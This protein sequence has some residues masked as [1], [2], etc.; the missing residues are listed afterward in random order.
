MFRIVRRA[1]AICLLAAALAA[2]AAAQRVTIGSGGAW[3]EAP[4]VG[5]EIELVRLRPEIADFQMPRVFANVAGI[6]FAITTGGRGS[7]DAALRSDRFRRALYREA[8]LSAVAANELQRLEPDAAEAGRQA[9]H[10]AIATAVATVTTVAETAEDLGGALRALDPAMQSP[11]LEALAQ[12][13][14][15]LGWLDFALGLALDLASEADRVALLAEAAADAELM[16]TLGALRRILA[17]QTRPDPAMLAGI[18][19]A[20]RDVRQL[21][22]SRLRQFATTGGRA[23]VRQAVPLGV[24]VAGFKMGAG[25][26][27][28]VVREAAELYGIVSG[29]AFRALLV[30]AQH[31]LA[32]RA[33]APLVMLIEDGANQAGLDA[34]SAPLAGLAG[35]HTRLR[36]E[37][38]AATYTALW[39]DRWES[40]LS[41]GAIGRGIG[42]SLAER[43]AGR[44][45]LRAAYRREV[46][47]R[48]QD[49]LEAAALSAPS[50]GA[51]ATLACLTPDGR[52]G[53]RVGAVADCHP[54]SSAILRLDGAGVAELGFL[55]EFPRLR[56]L[57]ILNAADLRDA[58]ALAGS[59]RP[60]GLTR[61]WLHGLDHERAPL[62]DLAGI[63]GVASL[64]MSFEGASAGPVRLADL[65]GAGV[66]EIDIVARGGAG[67]DLSGFVLSEATSHLRLAQ[68]H[69]VLDLSGLGGRL[70]RLDI[71]GLDDDGAGLRVTGLRGLG[72]LRGL[73]SLGVVRSG[74][75]TLDGIALA[76]SLLALR[77]VE[78]EVADAAALNVP[79]GLSGAQFDIG[80]GGR[81]TGLAGFN[82][83]CI[84]NWPRLTTLRLRHPDGLD[85]EYRAGAQRGG[86]V[87]SLSD[88][89][90]G[91]AAAG[92]PPCSD[93]DAAA[94]NDDAPAFAADGPLVEWAFGDGAVMLRLPEVFERREARGFEAVFTPEG[95]TEREAEARAGR[96]EPVV[97]LMVAK[98]RT[99]FGAARRATEQ[100]ARVEGYRIS[101]GPIPPR[102]SGSRFAVFDG[103]P[104]PA[105]G[106]SA[107]PDRM[108]TL[109]LSA[110][111]SDNAWAI[112][113]FGF[114]PGSEALFH[115]ARTAIMDSI[116]HR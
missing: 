18:D 97:V 27:A 21:S 23:A 42:M 43:G 31:N 36:A 109:L 50:V 8:L 74:I 46:A 39:T 85:E 12:D 116:R 104:D 38:T 1:A 64:A 53:L 101:E 103:V 58:S 115:A 54:L 71:G 81:I 19:D 51:T 82:P 86:N 102:L 76:T 33:Q 80:A 20:I 26:P 14:G 98:G 45:G 60:E 69:G 105:A 75:D 10:V 91:L 29:F 89:L 30:A 73:K 111:G 24:L 35:L 108:T 15:A 16:A 90:A 66:R 61:V 11:V 44:D 72:A 96:G 87:E 68:G 62:R 56:R 3:I 65:G 88:Y 99:D 84:A 57:V 83:R 92:L 63:D 28:M 52:E 93:T 41:L 110:P 95:I 67:L 22:E 5:D 94:R 32:V 47:R 78:V 106:N 77:L 107:L 112:G 49:H 6:G 13:A 113:I 55:A 7:L 59:R 114:N 100:N 34:A 37:A 48:A 4:F 40:P 2:P 79:L 25:G 9:R 70:E 17:V